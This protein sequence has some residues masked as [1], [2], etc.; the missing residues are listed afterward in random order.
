MDNYAKSYFIAC[1]VAGIRIDYNPD[2]LMTGLMNYLGNLEKLYYVIGDVDGIT[3]HD[4]DDVPMLLIK[5]NDKIITFSTFGGFSGGDRLFD[6]GDVIINTI[7]YLQELDTYF[8]PAIDVLEMQT[9]P[10]TTMQETLEDWS[11]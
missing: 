1:L 8:E 4:S 11:L 6:A 10:I 5:Y 3:I 2:E 9:T 7:T